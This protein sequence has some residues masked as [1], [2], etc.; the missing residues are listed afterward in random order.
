MPR[1]TAGT[2][3]VGAENNNDGVN[4]SARV[5]LNLAPAPVWTNGVYVANAPAATFSRPGAPDGP[6]D[7]LDIGVQITD[8]DGGSLWAA[9]NMLPTNNTVCTPGTAT[10]NG[11]CTHQKLAGSP[12]RMRYGRLRMLNAYG[13]ELLALPMSLTAEYWANT[14]WVTNTLDGCTSVPVPTSASGMVFGAGNLSAGETVAS[15]N[16]TTTGNGTLIAGDAGF[17][18]S[19]PG[20]GNTGFVTITVATPDWLDFPWV[21]AGVNVDASARATFGLF[22]SPLIYRRENY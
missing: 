3:A 8:P 13:S 7:A 21:T 19:A 12:A 14:G 15:I 1:Y 22:K 4:R 11:T 2:V 18:L 16:G 6:F 17:R 10:T 20:S 9:R 5:A